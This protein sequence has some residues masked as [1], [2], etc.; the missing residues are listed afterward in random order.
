MN[1]TFSWADLAALT[2]TPGTGGT[3]R[4]SPQDFLVEELPAYTPSGEGEFIFLRLEK[5]GHTTVFVVR[6]LARQLGLDERQVGVAGL[7]DR[8]AVTTQWLSLPAKAQARL[9]RFEL[10]G[11]RVLEVARHG[12]KLGI[13]HLRGNRFSVRVRGA[14]GSAQLAQATLDQLLRLGVPNYFGPQ[15]FGLGGL[16][17]QEGLRVMRGESRLRDP[18]LK[19]F[20]VSSVQS[21]LFNAFVSARIERG[22]FDRLLEGDMAKKHDTGGVFR[23]GDADAETL[24]ALRGE[25]SATGTLFGR[26]VQPLTGA[27]GDLER[28]L[29]AR[30]GLTPEAFS[31]RK[32]DRRPVRVFAQEARLH[33]EEDGY[34]VT[35]DLPKGSFATAVLREL[36]KTE[37]DV[38]EGPEDEP[39]AETA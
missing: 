33:A 5:V 19:R 1:L 32:G 30:F 12:N 11:V 9:P 23:V 13:G 35:F 25:V 21:A 34:R 27:A 7:K 22:V 16:N 36:L 2:D 37:V 28:E 4:A 3:L 29:L 8:H 15:R 18:R 6:E 24:R 31:S 14:A 39:E 17:A 26:K 20:L 38:G 10:S